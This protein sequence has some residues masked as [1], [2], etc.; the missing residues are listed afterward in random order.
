VSLAGHVAPVATPGGVVGRIGPV[1]TPERFRRRGYAAA[2]TAAVARRLQARCSV[3]MLFADAANPTS[4]G[5]YR[6]L[7]FHPAGEVVDVE[8]AGTA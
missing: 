4:N 1:F 7:G 2:V 5:V 6:R 8:L 3:V